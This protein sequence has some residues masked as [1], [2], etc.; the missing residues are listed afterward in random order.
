[1]FRSSSP[2]G[3]VHHVR[4]VVAKD[5][6]HAPKSPW[7]VLVFIRTHNKKTLCKHRPSMIIDVPIASATPDTRT[8]KY[9]KGRGARERRSGHRRGIR[10]E[11]IH[12]NHR[13]RATT[14]PPTRSKHNKTRIYQ[15]RLPNTP[16]THRAI[17][18][19]IPTATA[20]ARVRVRRHQPGRNP[21]DRETLQ[22]KKKTMCPSQQRIP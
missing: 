16:H 6:T 19:I 2:L 13:L 14:F 17:E 7:G 4:K 15:K 5:Q 18:K 11:T 21:A 22:T 12:P 20:S 1:M 9:K 10:G 8:A 3:I